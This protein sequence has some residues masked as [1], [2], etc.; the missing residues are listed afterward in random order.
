MVCTL[1]KCRRNVGTLRMQT[2]KRFARPLLA[3]LILIGT[4]LVAGFPPGADNFANAPAIEFVTG[5]SDPTDLG[6][7]TVEPNEPSH[8]PTGVA[9]SH[10]AWW[11][12][13]PVVPGMCTVDT[14]Y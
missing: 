2:P 6:A 11:K 4:P 7:C 3:S 8:H 1:G 10:T 12:W 5:I 13:S 14:L 9:P